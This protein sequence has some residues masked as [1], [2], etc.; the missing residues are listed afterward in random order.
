MK[1]I[2]NEFQTGAVS[3]R[4]LTSK[5]NLLVN[6]EKGLLDSCGNHPEDPKRISRQEAEREA[7]ESQRKR[8]S[9]GFLRL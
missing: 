2:V 4:V 5:L 6:N 8:Q 3:L 7:K 9:T 1:K